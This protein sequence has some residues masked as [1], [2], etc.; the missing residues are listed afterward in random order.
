MARFTQACDYVCR[1][2][3]VR[4]VPLERPVVFQVVVV[5]DTRRLERLV[6]LEVAMGIDGEHGQRAM[7]E[8]GMMV[9]EVVVRKAGKSASIDPLKTGVGS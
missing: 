1:H 8:V 5:K 7:V 2:L 6:G 4:D 3:W 9:C